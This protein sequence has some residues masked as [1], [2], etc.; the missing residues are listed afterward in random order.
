MVGGFEVD[1]INVGHS[2]SQYYHLERF[3]ADGTSDV[4]FNTHAAL[5]INLS[6]S[7][8]NHSAYGVAALEDYS[9]GDLIRTI[10]LA[11]EIPTAQFAVQRYDDLGNLDTS[12]GT[13][14]MLPSGN[15]STGFGIVVDGGGKVLAGVSVTIQMG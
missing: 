14:G 12:L 15:L 11:G 9:T 4:S 1:E 3:N 2:T 13:N 7:Q 8:H 6:E 5:G 10:V